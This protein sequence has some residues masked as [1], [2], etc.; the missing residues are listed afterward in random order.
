MS[1]DAR[2]RRFFPFIVLAML[3]LVAY[4]QAS[5]IGSLIASA[6][7]ED[8]ALQA[9]TAA[10]PGE[11]PEPPDG[12]RILARN[13]FDSSAGP[14]DTEPEDGE[15]EPV[16]DDEPAE[17]GGRCSFGRVTLIVAAD[18]PRYA[19]ASIA[20]AD[21]KPKMRWVG[22]AVDDHRV[23]SMTWDRVVLEKGK[24]RCHLTVG[25]GKA[26]T[27]PPEPPSD[28]DDLTSKIRK[29][30]DTEFEID[31]ATAQELLAQE[32]HLENA[33][34]M[35]PVKEGD[36][37]VGLHLSRVRP[38]TLFEAIGLKNGDRLES[39]NGI[40]MTNPVEAFEGYRK[41][42]SSGSLR[43][44]IRRADQPLTIAVRVK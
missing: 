23:T 11:P 6:V 42:E 27:T 14:L 20:G 37:V 7:S 41:L 13:P 19:F 35:R 21:G 4:F 5:A 38:G 31:R 28:P 3:G 43:I 29:V 10:P 12:G 25:E 2:L 17:S 26:A 18:D 9:P 30:S 22:D 44:E 36:Q 40:S 16:G 8:A 34:R 24:S 32:R 1:F 39:I 15:D 33:A